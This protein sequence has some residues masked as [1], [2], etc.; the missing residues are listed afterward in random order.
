MDIIA[1]HGAS[2]V[3]F[4]FARLHGFVDA[5]VPQ[6]H[7]GAFGRSGPVVAVLSSGPKLHHRGCR[8][9]SP[10]QS[11]AF[12]KRPGGDYVNGDSRRYPGGAVRAQL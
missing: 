5:T 11:R 12:W 8:A 3:C 10:A 2:T 7:S 1:F 4:R 6:V 9:I